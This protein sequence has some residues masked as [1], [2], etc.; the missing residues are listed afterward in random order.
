MTCPQ[1]RHLG[2]MQIMHKNLLD[3]CQS[4]LQHVLLRHPPILSIF[5]PPPFFFPLSQ[6][7]QISF[8]IYFLFRQKK[9]KKKEFQRSLSLFCS[10]GRTSAVPA[11]PPAARF[12]AALPG[13]QGRDRSHRR[14]LSARPLWTHPCRNCHSSDHCD[15]AARHFQPGSRPGRDHRFASHNGLLGVRWVR[16]RWHYCLF[17]DLQVI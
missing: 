4:T 12:S 14:W 7:S 5:T 3:T 13:C 1:T 10:D 8:N 15:A 2:Y 11:V 9:K 6:I 17:M 16:G